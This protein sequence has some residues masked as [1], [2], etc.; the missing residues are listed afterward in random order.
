MTIEGLLAMSPAYVSMLVASMDADEK[1]RLS[2]GLNALRSAR[3]L[4]DDEARAATAAE[5]AGMS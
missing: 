1:A 5:K 3:D 4:T 2:E